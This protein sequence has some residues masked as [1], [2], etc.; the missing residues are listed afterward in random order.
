MTVK[1]MHLLHLQLHTGSSE[2][3]SFEFNSLQRAHLPKG[4]LCGVSHHFKSLFI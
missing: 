1:H 4:K 3:I 2:T